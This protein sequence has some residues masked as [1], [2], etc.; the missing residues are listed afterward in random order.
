ML[1]NDAKGWHGSFS[2]A[3]RNSAEKYHMIVHKDSI[4][5][6]RTKKKKIFGFFSTEEDC[7][8]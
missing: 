2:A 5:A 1:E 6:G 4:I 3:G 8:F 7:L